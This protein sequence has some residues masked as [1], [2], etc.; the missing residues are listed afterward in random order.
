V[1]SACG[2]DNP[3]APSGAQR[4]P[5]KPTTSLSGLLKVNLLTR[6]TA[7]ATSFSV[8]G[9]VGGKGATLSIPE[10]GLTVYFPAKAIKKGTV[11]ITA[12]AG[13]LLSYQFEPHGMTFAVPVVVTQDLSNTNAFNPGLNQANFLA[14]YTA[15]SGDIDLL[16]GT[17]TPAELLATIVDPVAKTVK[18]NIVHFSGY[19]VASGLVDGTN[20]F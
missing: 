9:E 12:V 7:L 3:T 14:A 4:Q 11:T 16:T 6:N 18:F 13:R 8:S 10:A 20:P 17:A 15:S 1:A 2:T 19:A 5:S